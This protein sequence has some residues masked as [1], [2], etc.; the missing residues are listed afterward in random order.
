MLQ[1]LIA[2]NNVPC[3]WHTVGG[4]H[5]CT[6]KE[7]FDLYV[8]RIRRL[9]RTDPDLAAQIVLVDD[10]E[11]LAKLRV[12]NA[13]GA[14]LQPMAAK[15]WPY[16]LVAWVLEDLL[17]KNSE[18]GSVLFNLQTN[19]PA[20]RLQRCEDMW[21]VHTP[22]GQIAAKEVLLATNAYTSHLLP[23]LTGLV[24]PVR[25]QVCALEPP[26]TVKTLEH[27]HVWIT[28]NECDDYLIH[29]SGGGPLMLGGERL[30]AEAGEVGISRDDSVNPKIGNKLR[31]A[32]HGAV[33]IQAPD[34]P[35]P[36][37]LPASWEWT[38]IM[39]YSLDGY[40]WVGR[41]PE[42]AGGGD[43]L[44]IAAGYTGHGMP[45]AAQCA[46]RVVEMMLGK[47]GGEVEMPAEFLMSEERLEKARLSGPM[48]INVSA[49]DELKELLRDEDD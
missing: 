46:V 45:V 48:K 16:K 39:G 29:R 21:I 9:E 15:L 10:P 32:L 37:A 31:H 19:T 4:V 35:D 33:K 23:K 2:E 25:G 12:P 30:S 24:V 6:S 20:L 44:W 41:V 13:I 47:A 42:S 22:R 26:E 34:T 43:G 8:E 49:V 17:A 38:G 40:P 11:E 3:D 5:S 7:I 36:P 28:P 1:K 27:S 18:H 14:F